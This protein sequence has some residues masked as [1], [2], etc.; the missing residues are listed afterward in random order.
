MSMI[1]SLRDRIATGEENILA[2]RESQ[3]RRK[4]HSVYARDMYGIGKEYL[5]RMFLYVK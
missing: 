4:L 5:S 1:E 3:Q 2:E